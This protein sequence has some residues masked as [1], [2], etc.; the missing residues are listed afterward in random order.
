VSTARVL[1]AMTIL[2]CA[3]ACDDATEIPIIPSPPPPITV[4]D[5]FTVEVY[6]SGLDL[7]T[8]IDFPPD[9]S[10][11]LF[12]N[13]LQSGEVR[14]IQ[15]GEL[16]DQPFAQVETN[17]AGGFPVA[18]ENGLLGIAFDPDYVVNRY[19][20]VTYATRMDSSTFGTV[21]R[22]TDVGNRGEDFTVL[23]DSLPSA[24]G[25]QVESLAFGPDGM[26]YVSVGDAFVT[27]DVQ[28]TDTFAG[29]IL[30]M[31][32]DGSI[33]PDNPFPGSYTYAYGFRNA[34]D[35]VFDEA[36]ELFSAD[37][38]PERDDELNRII[39]AGNYGWP[40]HL[41]A[42]STPGF[43]SPLHV[44]PLIVAPGGMLFYA[45]TQ[46]PA[47]F[48][49]RLL[50]VL[51]GDTFA[52]GPSDRAKRVQL[53]DIASTPPVFEDLAVYDFAGM[54]NPLDIAEG[55]DGSVFLS[56]I[57]QGRIFRVAYAGG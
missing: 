30:R 46:F 47:A 28:D 8:S 34:F 9:G 32:P 23:L 35:L 49:G 11:R 20:Y 57:F 44:W 19:V 43:V 38:G 1:R 52:A 36:G 18:G 15:D 16:L 22:F 4:P 7:P 3:A 21:A 24:A 29:K 50:I 17:T 31:T 33:P 48:R 42:T 14:I 39:A 13:E 56:D 5:G 27:D 54:G 12:V 10:D 55:P 51:F 2:A 25:H 37:N 40:V 45:G 53:V 26:L 41:G 6:A